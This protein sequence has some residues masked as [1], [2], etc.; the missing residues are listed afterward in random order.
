M[1]KTL[2]SLALGMSLS[3]P[4]A[5]EVPFC[6]SL[7]DAARTTMEA[8]QVGV[9]M[10]TLWTE[11]AELDSELVKEMVKDAYGRPAYES[12]EYQQESIEEF[13]NMWFLACLQSEFESK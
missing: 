5:A 2:F 1:K 13:A 8:R 9:P 12:A 6:D 11:A 7:E 4:V 3:L 10:K